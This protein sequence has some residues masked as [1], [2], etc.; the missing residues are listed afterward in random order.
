MTAP[1]PAKRALVTGANRGIGLETCRQLGK[2]GWHVVATSRHDPFPAKAQAEIYSANP[3]AHFLHLD[4]TQPTTISAVADHFTQQSW[5]LDLL[6]NNAGIL[7]DR[8]ASILN[9]KPETLTQTL[10]TNTLGPIQVTQT[11]LPFLSAANESL[12]MNVSS[13]AGSLAEMRD[14][15]PA[16]SISKCALNAATRQLAAAVKTQNISV[17]AVSPGWVRTQMGGPGATRS[18]P[19][20]VTSMLSLLKQTPA[21]LTARFL[22]DNEDVPW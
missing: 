18:I 22:R 9:T 17:V 1:P 7:L 21:D 6:V 19:E 12:V 4:L 20:A 14:W 15:A 2:A 13:A 5:A 10:T 8:D 11:L 3:T 16:Y